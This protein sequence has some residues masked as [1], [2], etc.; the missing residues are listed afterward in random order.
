MLESGLAERQ[1]RVTVLL[2]EDDEGQAILIIR[3]LKRS[4]MV[5]D[6][7]HFSDGEQILD[8]LLRRGTGPQRE[9]GK[10]YVALVDIRMPK[11]DGL[12]VL[13]KVKADEELRVLP[14]IMVTT[15]NDP[16][17]IERCHYYGCSTYLTKP[18]DYDRFVE[19]I[20]QLGRFL[21]SVEVPAIGRG[22]S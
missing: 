4:G 14:V 20:V 22:E 2:A 18:V 15:N 9:P 16:R 7:I 19:A 6:I 17:E 3:N 5:H 11:V 13:R 21:Q 1:R 8:F 10:K 12:E